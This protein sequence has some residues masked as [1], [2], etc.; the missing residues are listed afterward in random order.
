[1]VELLRNF[2]GGAVC[3]GVLGF[4]FPFMK[5]LTTFRKEEKVP[6]MDFLAWVLIGFLIGGAM[7]AVF[8]TPAW[9]GLSENF[10]LNNPALL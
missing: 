1:M 5:N 9:L 2:L 7:G 10:Y 3:G 8:F 6:A 4:F